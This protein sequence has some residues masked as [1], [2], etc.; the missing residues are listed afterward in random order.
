MGQQLSQDP[1]SIA[2]T[3]RQS[4]GGE[5]IG[6]ELKHREHDAWAAILCEMSA[7]QIGSHRAQYYDANGLGRHRVGSTVDTVLEFLIAEGFTQ[8]DPGRL[9]QLT[10]TR[11]WQ[12]RMGY[13]EAA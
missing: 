7:P 1:A 10:A 2:E 5:L 9:R 8:P 13:G 12:L 11:Q 6:L 3:I 4:C